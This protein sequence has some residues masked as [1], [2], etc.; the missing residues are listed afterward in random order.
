MPDP[1]VSAAEQAIARFVEAAGRAKKEVPAAIEAIPDPQQALGPAQK[2]FRA[3]EAVYEAM[4]ELRAHLVGTIWESE[5]MTA[6]A[7]ADRLNI[8]RQRV[9]QIAKAQRAG[10][11]Q[12]P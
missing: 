5:E 8:T 7:L 9:G 11:E 10:K 3:A 4:S 2:A 1:E 12:Q 6:A